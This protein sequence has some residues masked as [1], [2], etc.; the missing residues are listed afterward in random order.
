MSESNKLVIE[1]TNLGEGSMRTIKRELTVLIEDY[2]WKKMV[3]KC[4]NVKGEE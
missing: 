4:I 1:L 2:A 3:S